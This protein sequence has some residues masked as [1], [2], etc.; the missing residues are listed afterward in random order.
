MEVNK[1][2]AKLPQKVL[3]TA[4]TAALVGGTSIGFA[5][6]ATAAEPDPSVLGGLVTADANVNLLNQDSLAK[7]DANVNLNLGSNSSPVKLPPLL[8]PITADANL[9]L[10]RPSTVSPSQPLSTANVDVNIGSGYVAPAA[11]LP[12]PAP[13]APAPAPVQADPA[14]EVSVALN[15]ATNTADGILS[16]FTGTNQGGLTGQLIDGTADIKIGNLEPNRQYDFLLYTDNNAD[17]KPTLLGSATSNLEGFAV[18]ALPSGLLPASSG[19]DSGLLNID[20]NTAGE[21]TGVAAADSVARIV[22]LPTGTGVTDNIPTADLGVVLD[23]MAGWVD[24]VTGA[25][26]SNDGSS[27]GNDSNG[28]GAAAGSGTNG[29]NG[30]GAT[31]VLNGNYTTVPVNEVASITPM[32]AETKEVASRGLFDNL[33]NTALA[34]TGINGIGLLAIGGVLVGAGAFLLRR[35]LGVTP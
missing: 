1:M 10:A 13:A 11:P 28:A 5:S 35:K 15:A 20:G 30:S 26:G 25:S 34:N 19:S 29:S 22:V 3:A 9:N 31:G 6:A 17:T 14:A 4:V 27:S 21:T 23:N 32:S 33:A 7:A 8:S 24:P 2:I 18:L 12:A 16:T